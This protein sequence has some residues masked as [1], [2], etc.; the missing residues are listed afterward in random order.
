[1]VEEGCCSSHTCSGPV[2][3]LQEAAKAFDQVLWKH[4]FRESNSLADV[5][6]KEG[7]N[8]SLGLRVFDTIPSFALLPFLFDSS[9]A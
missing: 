8:A 7:M 1:M 2:L 9:G 5:F 3:Q 4:V 6:A